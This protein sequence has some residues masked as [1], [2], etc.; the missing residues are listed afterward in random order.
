MRAL[1]FTSPQDISS[2]AVKDFVRQA[3]KLDAAET[4]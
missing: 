4:K 2:A 3:V 1:R